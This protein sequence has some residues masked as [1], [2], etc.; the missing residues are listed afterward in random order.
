MCKNN[1]KLQSKRASLICTMFYG[2]E[3]ISDFI[4]DQKNIINSTIGIKYFNT[5][6]LSLL[7]MKFLYFWNHF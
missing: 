1:T 5:F 6:F 4:R 7:V 2:Y 3:Q